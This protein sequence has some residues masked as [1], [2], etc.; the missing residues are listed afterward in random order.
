MVS[1]ILREWQRLHLADEVAVRLE[2]PCRTESVAKSP[3][4]A[5]W[6]ALSLAVVVAGN[7]ACGSVPRPKH[8]NVEAD[9]SRGEKRTEG[10]GGGGGGHK[11]VIMHN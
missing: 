3:S 9:V 5:C 1:V 8:H 11:R 10:E 7:G 2:V 6:D 4:P